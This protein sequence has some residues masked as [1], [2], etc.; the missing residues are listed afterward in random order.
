MQYS[1]CDLMA[2]GGVLL[3]CLHLEILLTELLMPETLHHLKSID[4][5][6]LLLLGDVSV[7]YIT[8]FSLG[9]LGQILKYYDHRVE[10]VTYSEQQNCCNVL[11]T[12]TNL[13]I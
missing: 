12:A 3:C 13:L 9:S 8:L 11:Y 5:M 10:Q 2:E 1:K 4:S 6:C 7:S